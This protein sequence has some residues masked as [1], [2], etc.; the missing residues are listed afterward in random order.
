MV[1]VLVPGRAGDHV[2]DGDHQVAP[3]GELQSERGG[4][5]GGDDAALFQ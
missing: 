2:G 1:S 4:G 3:E 5:P